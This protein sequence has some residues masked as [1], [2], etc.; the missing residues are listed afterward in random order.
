[1]TCVIANVVSTHLKAFRYLVKL[2]HY[3]ARRHTVCRYLWTDEDHKAFRF[4]IDDFKRRA[5]AGVDVKLAWEMADVLDETIDVIDNVNGLPRDGKA[6]K[7]VKYLRGRF[8]RCLHRAGAALREFTPE[9]E[10]G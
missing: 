8:L 4:R 10:Y 3:R 7:R 6:G 2:S 9:K 5:R 1:M